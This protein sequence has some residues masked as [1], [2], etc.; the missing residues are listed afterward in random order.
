MTTY[1]LAGVYYEFG[2]GNTVTQFQPATF[3]FTLV[4]GVSTLSYT[5]DYAPDGVSPTT[6]EFDNQGTQLFAPILDA[7]TPLDPTNND[8][9]VVELSWVDDFGTPKTTTLL[10]ID[11]LTGGEYVFFL[12]GDPLPILNTLA[13][14]QDFNDNH[15]TGV[16]DIP[17][18]TT[19]AEGQAISVNDISY[20]SSTENDAFPGTSANESIGAGAGAD[21]IYGNGGVDT[22]DGGAGEDWIVVTGDNDGTLVIGGGDFDDVVIYDP[23]NPDALFVDFTH[24]GAGEVQIVGRS[25][26][27]GSATVDYTITAVEIERVSIEFGTQSGG[28]VLIQ[29]DSTDDRVRFN[30]LP[31]FWEF[32][33]GDGQDQVDLHRTWV[34]D[35]TGTRIRG[36]SSTFLLDNTNFS[37]NGDTVVVSNS[38]GSGA[39]FSLTDVEFIRLTDGTFSTEQLAAMDAGQSTTPTTGD[40]NLF[41]TVNPDSIDGDAGNDVISGLGGNDTLI[42][43]VG[44]DTLYGG[45]DDDTLSGGADNDVINGGTGNDSVDG[46]AGDDTLT[47]GRGFDTVDGGTGTDTFYRDLAADFSAQSW[48]PIVDL[49]AGRFYDPADDPSLFDT[50]LNIEN[51][52][53]VG[54]FDMSITG[55]GNGNVLQSDLGDDTVIGGAGN[56]TLLGG[57]G[58]DTLSGGAD[59]DVIDGGFGNDSI[60]GGAGDDTLT[61]GRGFDTVDGGT[62]TDTFY[63]DLAAD[64]TA[65]SW[66]PIV[67]LVAGRFY[68]P[69]DDPSLFDTLLNIENVQLVG[70]FDMSITG[71]GNG[72]VLQSDLGDDTVIGGSGSDTLISGAGND[73]LQGDLGNDLLQGGDDNDTLNG[74]F[75]ADT[76]EG[77]SGDDLLIGGYGDD[78]IDGGIGS[79]TADYTGFGGN[80]TVNLNDGTA[81]YTGAAG[82]DILTGIENL[83]GGDHADRFTGRP[84]DSILEGGDSADT[85]LGLGGDD[86]LDG[87]DGNDNIVGGSGADHLIGGAG[88]D[89]LLGGT[90]NDSLD[91]GIENDQLRGGDGEDTLY[92]GVGRDILIGGDFV[93][94][95]F[96]GDGAADTFVYTDVTESQV[97]AGGRDIIRDFEDGLDI[98]DLSAIDAITGTPGD[99]AFTFIGS[100]GFSGTAG[101]LR[102]VTTAAA[103]IVQADVDGDGNSDFDVFLNGVL[104]MDTSDFVL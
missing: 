83:V 67:D 90:E 91:G 8:T 11:I 63:R 81:Q 66:L 38:D 102:A 7:T 3:S 96:P 68:D 16:R 50:L 51:V 79:D 95:G 17:A 30:E 87:Q 43:G 40:D 62:G 53:L 99:D 32:L 104:V 54:D 71:D 45:E 28:D 5:Y 60:D 98:M 85:L 97:G 1:T 48:L 72:N 92:G 56:D 100:S 36:I 31:N 94:G 57:E 19:F 14:F 59:N 73:S 39:V 35:D 2:S 15:I 9:Y 61:D 34:E 75:S 6:V 77:G 84:D 70:D 23:T 37:V 76:L 33:G 24:G 101:E 4:D 55:D 103:T 29:G 42:G 46:G 25:D 27:T 82:T 26:H 18:G 64:F 41:G 89:A 69:A 52:Q 78:S 74:G 44:N 47:D 10:Q 58:N 20:F 65:Q 13:E 93:A 12:D 80:I 88:R 86:T 49:V 21:E 22:L